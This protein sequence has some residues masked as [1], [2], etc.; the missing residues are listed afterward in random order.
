MTTFIEALL[1]DIDKVA[2]D[3][4]GAAVTVTLKDRDG[5][6]HPLRAFFD[7]PQSDVPAGPAAAAV[8]AG[9]SVLHIPSVYV[10]AAIGRP[11][12]TKDSVILNGAEYAC[13]APRDD[14]NGM[15]V[16]KLQKKGASPSPFPAFPVGSLSGN[17]GGDG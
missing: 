14:A 15:V 5:G 6:E 7:S 9:V 8:I 4:K 10:S 12:T 17:G 2:R 1:G 13:Q 11:L 3:K 16:V